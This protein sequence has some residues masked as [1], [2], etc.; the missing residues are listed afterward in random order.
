MYFNSTTTAQPLW[1]VVITILRNHY[2]LGQSHSLVRC[3]PELGR[4]D[5]FAA[6]LCVTPTS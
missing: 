5:T 1:Q 2:A 3:R 6:T 4:G